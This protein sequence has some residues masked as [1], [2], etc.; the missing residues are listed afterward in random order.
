MDPSR[1]AAQT[2]P[3]STFRKNVAEGGI[4][5][6]KHEFKPLGLD[7]QGVVASGKTLKIARL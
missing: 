3:T 4:G 7:Q 5:G 6:R 2:A 1:M